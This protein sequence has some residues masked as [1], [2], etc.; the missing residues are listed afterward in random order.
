VALEDLQEVIDRSLA[1]A[2]PLSRRVYAND[3]WTAVAVQRFVNRVMAATVATARHDGLPHAAVVL[4][5]CLDGTLHFTASLGSVLLRNLQRQPAVS[6]T[7]ADRDHD[8]TVHGH[9]EALGKASD[10]AALVA[11]LH[12]L[13]RRGQFL[14]RDW[15]GYIYAVGVDRIFL[16]K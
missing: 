6:M 13:S 4:A 1:T 14:P 3:R 16:S 7:I 2:S 15:D 5:A 10:L 11:E 9:G 12:A 8:L